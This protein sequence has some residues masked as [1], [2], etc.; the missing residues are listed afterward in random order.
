MGIDWEGILDAEGDDLQDA[1]DDNV[2]RS[3]RKY[4]YNYDHD[5]EEYNYYTE[6]EDDYRREMSD[7]LWEYFG[8]SFDSTPVVPEN[9]K[10]TNNIKFLIDNIS[11]LLPEKSLPDTAFDEYYSSYFFV[12]NDLRQELINRVNSCNSLEMKVTEIDKFMKKIEEERYNRELE[13]N[14]MIAELEA[15]DEFETIEEI[16]TVNEDHLDI[17][18]S[19]KFREDLKSIIFSLN[20]VTEEDAIKYAMEWFKP[21]I[22]Q[23]L[24]SWQY[25]EFLHDY[26]YEDYKV[27][28]NFGIPTKF[29]VESCTINDKKSILSDISTELE[30]NKSRINNLVIDKVLFY[31]IQGDTEKVREEVTEKYLECWNALW[32]GIRSWYIYNGDR[33]IELRL[34][35]VYSWIYRNIDEVKDFAD[36]VIFESILNVIISVF[37]RY[38]NKDKSNLSEQ[39]END[40]PVSV[41]GGVVGA[42]TSVVEQTTSS[43]QVTQSIMRDRSD[44]NNNRDSIFKR[45]DNGAIE[46]PPLFEN[47]DEIIASIGLPPE[48]RKLVRPTNTKPV[49]KSVQSLS[50]NNNNDTGV[51][52]FVH[53]P[54][55]DDKDDIFIDEFNPFED[56]GVGTE[57]TTKK[58]KDKNTQDKS[59]F[60]DEDIANPFKD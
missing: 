48:P 26:G 38:I 18:A 42:T 29:K 33:F 55:A 15:Y 6:A 28:Y 32:D 7:A 16:R 10:G 53:N 46:I 19:V 36:F 47:I 13:L 21:T 49:I 3:N 57:K 58:D 5:Y 39:N 2:E 60:N 24:F 52:S 59:P 44:D 51:N 54:F 14:E 27:P 30:S 9:F 31:N 1:W 25:F 23:Q 37:D 45:E 12:Y 40:F 11:Q 41:N 20:G 50:S 8:N 4:E 17:I 43:K 34:G 56:F 22:F 35:R